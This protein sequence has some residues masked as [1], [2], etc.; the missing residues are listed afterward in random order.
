MAKWSIA[1]YNRFLGAA[2]HREHVT[3]K[4]AAQM[5]REVR[6]KLGRPVFRTDLLAHPRI[7]HKVAAHVKAT[8]VPPLVRRLPA[9]EA[10]AEPEGPPKWEEM[11]WDADQL[12]FE[13]DEEVT[14]SEDYGE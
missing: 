2:M 14:L 6:D 1:S 8:V 12:E 4:Q 7:T 5:Y 3:R 10:P 11:V 13:D 9:G